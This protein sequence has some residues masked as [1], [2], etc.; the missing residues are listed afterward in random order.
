MNEEL[1][2]PDTTHLDYGERSSVAETHAAVQREKREPLA[3]FQ[4]I[5]MLGVVV[6]GLILT[7]GGIY[8]GAYSGGFDLRSTYAIA[9]YEPAP[10]PIIP[11]YEVKVDNRP[12]ID[13]WMDGGKE[14]YAGC[15]ACHQPNGNGLVGQFP[16]LA[17]SEYVINGTERL[18]ALVFPGIMGSLTVKGQAY[19]GV[20]PA[21]GALLSDKQL[22]QVLTYIR[23]SFGNNASIVTEEMVKH[24][25]DKY[26]SRTQPWSEAE[27][28]AIPADAMLPGSDVDPQTGLAPGAAPAAPAPGS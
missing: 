7:L 13:K 24:A 3:A 23:R 5:S 9:N 16:P 15:A 18:G 4:P 8:L 26:G 10:R 22:A 1:P 19:N 17:Q 14:V 11:G 6:A 25:R 2:N 28:L 21:Q 20:M 27:L 12:W